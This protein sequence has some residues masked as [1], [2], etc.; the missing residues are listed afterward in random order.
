MTRSEERVLVEQAQ[1]DPRKF[2]ALYLAF[3]DDI[4]RFV[5]YKTSIKET[6]E[7]IT[8]LV[9]MQALEHINQ[10]R[11]TPGAKFSSWLYVIARHKIIDYYRKHHEMVDLDDVEPLNAPDNTVSQVD[12]HITQDRIRSV[13]CGLPAAD[14]EV[15]Q[16]RLWQDR[17]YSEMADILN[18]NVVAIRA[19]YSR[20]LKKFNKAYTERYGQND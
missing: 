6:A 4:Y 14:Q 17:S 8:S 11:Y 1:A 12:E 5:Y 9:F 20:A 15:L 3:I 10:F 19:R 16:L 7:D 18:S 2:D 13:L